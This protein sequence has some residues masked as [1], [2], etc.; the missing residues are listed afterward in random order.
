LQAAGGLDDPDKSAPLHHTI[1]IT[2]RDGYFVIVS[3]GEVAPEFGDK[4][5]IIAYQRGDKPLGDAGFRLV[6]QGDKRNGRNVR[7]VV[8]VDVE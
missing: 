6:L 3:T 5:A 8:R 7:D 2:G 1:K 4:Q